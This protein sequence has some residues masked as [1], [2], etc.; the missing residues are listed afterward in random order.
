M[1]VNFVKMH[2][3]GN[4]FVVIELITQRTHLNK[5]HLIKI[6]N[7]KFGIGC[8][9][10]ILL[11]PPQ[12]PDADFY[13][14]IYNPDGSE[15]EQCVNGLR[16]AAKLFVDLGLTNKTELVAEC[17]A[18]VAQV[19]V[20]ADLITATWHR[21]FPAVISKPINFPNLPAQIHTLSIGNPH[22]VLVVDKL[23]NHL[24]KVLGSKLSRDPMFQHGANIGFMQVVDRDTIQLRVFERGAGLTLACGSGACAAVLAGQHLNL[25]NSQVTVIFKYGKLTVN[26]NQEQQVL[27]MSGPATS[28]Y[29]GRFKI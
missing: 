7:R 10:V 22:G 24:I 18:G 21:D 2:G 29:I 3:L 14:K 1:I 9:Q 15:A 25:L 12:R 6:A 8:D 5:E 13:Y 17:L 28:V 16:C 27:S 11:T 23:D 20:N 26:F 19:K 4:D